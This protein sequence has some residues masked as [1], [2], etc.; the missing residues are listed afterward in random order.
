MKWYTGNAIQQRFR[1][2]RVGLVI[3]NPLI[4]IYFSYLREKENGYEEGCARGASLKSAR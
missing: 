1:L 2:N 3:D 4:L